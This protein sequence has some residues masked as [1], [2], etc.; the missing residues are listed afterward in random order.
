MTRATRNVGGVCDTRQNP[1]PISL[2]KTGVRRRLCCPQGFQKA[3]SSVAGSRPLFLTPWSLNHALLER[4]SNWLFSCSSAV[5]LPCPSHTQTCPKPTGDQ[6][7]GQAEPTLSWGGD[8]KGLLLIPAPPRL[9][10]VWVPLRGLQGSNTGQGKSRDVWPACAWMKRQT[11]A[12][13]VYVGEGSKGRRLFRPAAPLPSLNSRV[14]C[15]LSS[16]AQSWVQ[17]GW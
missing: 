6:V 14:T 7:L 10:P 4:D 15:G 1:Q 2:G 17:G 13:D 3:P 8:W 12:G 16:L 5:C 9:S 11:S